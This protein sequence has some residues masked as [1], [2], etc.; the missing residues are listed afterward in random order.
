MPS[1]TTIL[2][3]GSKPP[4]DSWTFVVVPDDL[5]A[6]LGSKRPAV[7]GTIAGVSFR[8]TV[9]RGEGVY[10]MPVPRALQVEANIARG[11]RVRVV[12]EADPEPRPVEIPPELADVLAADPDLARRFADLPPAH[13]RAWADHIA[14]A[15]REE[16]RIRRVA[17]AAEGIRRKTFPGAGSR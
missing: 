10:R 17:Q 12:M 11:D 13:R 15:K 14:G 16:T 8:G 2:V 4:Y 3:P 5:V 7:R 1:F 9:S 6:D